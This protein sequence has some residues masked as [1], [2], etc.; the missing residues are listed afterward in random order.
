MVEPPEIAMTALKSQ[1]PFP[2]TY[3][4][5]PGF[6]AVTATKTRQRNKLD[7][8]NPLWWPLS[9]TTL[10]WNLLGAKKTSVFSFI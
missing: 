2:K 3:P 5:E 1:M 8:S 9:P 7:I 10:R 6:S 4:W